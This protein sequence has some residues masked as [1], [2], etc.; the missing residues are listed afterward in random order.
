MTVI[1]QKQTL[2][3][4]QKMFFNYLFKEN[5]SQT[6]YEKSNFIIRYT[7]NIFSH[8]QDKNWIIVFKSQPLKSP[9]QNKFLVVYQAYTFFINF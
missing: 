7:P 4:D 6:V 5:H 9:I 3:V 1:F 2:V 8:I